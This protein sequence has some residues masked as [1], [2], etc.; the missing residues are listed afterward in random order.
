MGGRPR[1]PRPWFRTLAP[2]RRDSRCTARRR[3][4]RLAP[5]VLV[6]RRRCAPSHTALPEVPPRNAGPRRLPEKGPTSQGETAGHAGG[7]GWHSSGAKLKALCKA[8][9]KGF[10]SFRQKLCAS[11]PPSGV[12]GRLCGGLGTGRRWRPRPPNLAPAHLPS[13]DIYPGRKPR[14]TCAPS[15]RFWACR[16]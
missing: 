7:V 11:T 13:C 10:I 15:L 5:C 6:R 16:D 4:D 2:F 9:I 14:V 8:F 3:W 12:V 1:C